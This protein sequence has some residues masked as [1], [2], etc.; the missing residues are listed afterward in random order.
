MNRLLILVGFGG[1]LAASI[2]FAPPIPAMPLHQ[3]ISTIQ[4]ANGHYARASASLSAADCS[5]LVSVA[6]SLAMGQPIRRL[7]STHTLLAGQWP[8]AIPGARPDNLFVIGANSG[9]M[10]ARINGVGIEA[11][12]SGQL[13][14]IGAEAASPWEPQFQLWHIDERV[15]TVG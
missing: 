9:H 4:A 2:T 5:G 7:G 15:L 1:L 6:Q 12:T 10:V 11:T 14:K 3:V 8:H 13:F